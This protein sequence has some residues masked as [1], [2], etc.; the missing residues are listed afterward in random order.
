MTSDSASNQRHSHGK[1]TNASRVAPEPPNSQADQSDSASGHEDSSVA[2]PSTALQDSGNPDLERKRQADDDEKPLSLRA[3]MY[4]FLEEPESGVGAKFLSCFVLCTI[5]VSVVSLIAE[6]IPEVKVDA[7]A[8]QALK[9]IEIMSTAIFSLEYVARLLVCDAGPAGQTQLEFVRTPTNILDLLAIMPFYL[10]QAMSD[11]NDTSVLRV[12]R[13]VRLLRIFRI[14][15]LGKYSSGLHI[16]VDALRKSFNPLMILGF[17]LGIGVILFSSLLFYVEKLSCP[18]IPALRA[19]GGFEGYRA[20]CQS[21]G[22]GWTKPFNTGDL[23]CN[24]Y[25]SADD[26]PSIPATFW[27]SF[28]TMSTV[29]YG[30]VY[31]RTSAGRL[32]ASL[33]MLCGILLISLPVAIVGSKFQEVYEEFEIK[34]EEEKEQKELE[35]SRSQIEKSK[36][37]AGEDSSPGADEPDSNTGWISR[38]QKG[39]TF[40]MGEGSSRPTSSQMESQK[41]DKGQAERTPVT[42]LGA[43]RPPCPPTSGQTPRWKAS[44][45]QIAALRAML[46]KLQHTGMSESAQEQIKL[47]LL[48]FDQVEG[49]SEDS[50]ALRKKD[51]DLQLTICKEIEAVGAIYTKSA[52]CPKKEE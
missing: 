37:S 23:C 22:T 45:D 21:E 6:T 44:V 3:Q 5:M 27:W 51:H 50:E 42:P 40:K 2:H 8:G 39:L 24:E 33:S 19:Q 9:F 17:F 15:K 25:G 38:L 16:M 12:L 20:L 30:D 11:A 48:I 36:K 28:A 14:F 32:I 10:E 29:G 47:I 43:H 52:E 35:K 34:A 18:D 46:K 26:F 41:D 7:G 4:L 49:L 1:S 31:P 13:S